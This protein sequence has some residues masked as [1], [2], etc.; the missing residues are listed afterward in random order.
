MLGTVFLGIKH[1]S[2]NSKVPIRGGSPK[3]AEFEL[4]QYYCYRDI[5]FSKQKQQK[6]RK[7]K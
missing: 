2:T 5:L 6:R 4:A 3:M 7:A 1:V